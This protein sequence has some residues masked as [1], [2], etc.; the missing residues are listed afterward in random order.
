[1]GVR[2]TPPLAF[3]EF[4]LKLG[5]RAGN[6][7]V[8]LA[9]LLFALP[10]FLV[11]VAN[12]AQG[13]TASTTVTVE[14]GRVEVPDPEPA[15][16]VEPEDD[17]ELPVTSQPVPPPQNNVPAGPPAAEEPNQPAPTTAATPPTVE[18]PELPIDPPADE[19][20]DPAPEE[21][22]GP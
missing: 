8:I 2:H 20:P 12:G 1:M 5:P 9:T 19:D 18:I 21:P 11:G 4:L 13:F 3:M 6:T 15:V 16:I 7:I 22:T 10:M 17:P 14:G